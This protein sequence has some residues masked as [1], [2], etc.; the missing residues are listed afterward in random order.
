MTDEYLVG[1]CQPG[2]MSRHLNVHLLELPLKSWTENQV[3]STTAESV[4]LDSLHDD[5]LQYH[6]LLILR[7]MG[8]DRHFPELFWV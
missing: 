6:F 7:G 3:T 1:R 4:V 8:L 2:Y 5:M